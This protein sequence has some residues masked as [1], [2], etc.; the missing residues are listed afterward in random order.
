MKELYKGII[1]ALICLPIIL[2]GS[3]LYGNKKKEFDYKFIQDGKYYSFQGSFI[4]KAELDCLMNVI[5]DFEHLSKYTSGAKSIDLVRQGEDWYDVTYTYRRFIIFENKSTWRRIL[6]RDE[7][8]VLFEM[9]SNENNINII[10]KMLSSTGYYQIKPEKEGYQVEYFQECKLKPG[11]L[12]D[13][14]I[15]KAKKEAIRF[16]AVFKEY[17]KRT[18]D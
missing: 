6:K 7:K 9:M 11:F 5:W 2:S 1:I 14:Y 3:N 4:V 17:V 18:C 15:S 12:E 8:K 10:P 16:M 13:A